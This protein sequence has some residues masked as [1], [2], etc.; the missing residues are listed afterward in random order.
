MAAPMLKAE[1]RE[2][3]GKNKMSKERR[4]GN[5]PAVIYAKGKDTQ[6]IYLNAKEMDK[7]LY[8][9]GMS[10][11]IGLDLNGEKTYVIIKE[12]QRNTLKSGLLHIDLQTLDENQK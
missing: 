2:V 6:P 11:K 5:I 9:Y 1:V 12:V 7:I 8:Q 10:A 4:K 3:T